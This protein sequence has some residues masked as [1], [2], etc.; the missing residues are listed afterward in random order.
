MTKRTTVNSVPE[1]RAPA[2]AHRALRLIRRLRDIFGDD[3]VIEV[4]E[5]GPDAVG[6]MVEVQ[7]DR[8]IVVAEAMAEEGD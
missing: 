7:P 6:F 8:A 1:D 3:R 5:V 2:S 4:P